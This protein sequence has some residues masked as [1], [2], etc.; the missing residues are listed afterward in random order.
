MKFYKL[1]YALLGGAMMV[2]CADDIADKGGANDASNV[3]GST[4]YIGVTISMPS[5][6]YTR[7]NDEFD[8]GVD[9]E[10]AVNDAT[11]I[12]F[13]G[14]TEEE[15]KF[16]KA[17]RI[18][19]DGF[20]DNNGKVQITREKAAAFPVDFAKDADEKLW[21]LAVLN[22]NGILTYSQNTTDS[23]GKEIGCTVTVNGTQ[24]TS[25]YSF[26][27]FMKLTT[28][29]A[30]YTGAAGHE[31]HF[32]MI[33]TPYSRIQGGTTQPDFSG[34]SNYFRVLADVDRAKIY[35]TAD[36]AM[37]SPASEI[38]VE[39]AVA[40]V[41]INANINDLSN[42]LPE[43][44]KIKEVKW[45]LDNT[46]PSNYIVRN[47]EQV[48]EGYGFTN[49][50]SW[51]LYK[52]ETSDNYRFIGNASFKELAKYRT[53]FCAD[54][55]GDGLA[56]NGTVNLKRI[57]DNNVTPVYRNIGTNNPQYC[58]ENTFSVANMNYFNTTRCVIEVT[59][60]DEKGEDPWFYTIGLD[61]KHM[62]S[63]QDA[64]RHLA[65][66]VISEQLLSDAWTAYYQSKETAYDN[67]ASTADL[68]YSDDDAAVLT[69]TNN[70][71]KIT[72]SR[73][74]GR[75]KIAD[76][77]LY[78]GAIEGDTKVEVPFA[79]DETE[80]ATKKA[81]AIANINATLEIKAYEN[82]KAYYS[83]YIKHFGDDLTP[84]NVGDKETTNTTAESY[85]GATNTID[86]SA[87]QNYLGRYGLVRNN[88]YR[89]TITQINNFGEPTYRDLPLDGTPDDKVTK[90]ESIACKVNIMSWAVRNQNAQL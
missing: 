22:S 77:T 79:A 30:L 26:E 35:E 74:G 65:V 28:T 45:L 55:N 80:A 83:L 39:R 3:V 42:T 53:Y 89:L 18:G 13:K 37:A 7:A 19:S 85:G 8:N 57:T 76:L 32:F 41:D 84:W 33:N 60:E 62:Y 75:L 87:K 51:A 27:D 4:G 38:F 66:E 12:F 63:Y 31:T 16:Y 59:Y 70:W 14:T 48:S 10:Y 5:D 46:E 71:M 36:Q 67:N 40:K 90:E 81:E 6:A 15:A 69:A 86:D 1:T 25:D 29:S 68:V 24:M 44:I 88:W 56:V 20:A 9:R 11:V 43:G 78:D 34:G 23:N 50:P 47:L 54:P 21:A 58:R 72:F 64:A 73:T 17:Y 49:V 61:N 52:N 2:S 82:G